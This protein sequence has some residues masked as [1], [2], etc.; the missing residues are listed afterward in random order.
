MKNKDLQ[1]LLSTFDPD[2]EVFEIG[3]SNRDPVADVS[4]RRDRKGVGYL[5][6]ET[7][8]IPPESDEQRASKPEHQTIP[9][10]P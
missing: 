8:P 7:A 3:L 5:V 2:L 10:R 1:R 4:E 6:L 9:I